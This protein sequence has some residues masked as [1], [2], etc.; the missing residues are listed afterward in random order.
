MRDRDACGMCIGVE[1]CEDVGDGVNSR[2]VAMVLVNL[3]VA[4]YLN[5]YLRPIVQSLVEE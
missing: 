5:T 4:L 1:G 2:D 3:V